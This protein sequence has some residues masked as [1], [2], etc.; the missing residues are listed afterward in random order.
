MLVSWACAAV[1][2]GETGAA[3]LRAHGQAEAHPCNLDE[4]VD[5]AHALAVL[6]V[7]LLAQCAGL[8]V[9]ACRCRPKT[10]TFDYGDCWECKVTLEEICPE[11]AGLVGPGVLDVQGQAPR[12]YGW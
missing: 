9:Q 8:P 4:A 2:L 10:L 3:L 7:R 6:V 5:I 12:Q 11:I 1:S